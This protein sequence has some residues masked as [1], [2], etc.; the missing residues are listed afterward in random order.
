MGEGVANAVLDAVPIVGE[1]V[2]IATL[3]GG[4]FHS[5]SVKKKEEMKAKAID[6][7]TRAQGQVSGAIDVSAVLGQGAQSS[8][9]GLV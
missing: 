4:L 8:V 9:A 5:M 2:G 3:F 1:V 6:A 7:T